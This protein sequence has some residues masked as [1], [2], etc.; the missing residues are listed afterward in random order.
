MYPYEYDGYSDNPP[1]LAATP[2]PS[3]G[4]TWGTEMP[5]EP[6]AYSVENFEPSPPQELVCT[7]CRGVYRDPVEC[8]CRHVF[9]S[10][11]IR[12]WLGRDMSPG[13]RSCPI[14]RR[15]ISMS[16]VVPVVPLVTNMIARLTVRCPNRDTGCTAKVAMESLSCH[17][18]TCEFRR[19]QCPD[20]AAPMLASELST[21]RRESCSR[22]MA[23]CRGDCGLNLGADTQGDRECVR[24]MRCCITR[25]EGTLDTLRQQMAYTLQQLFYVNRQLRQITARMDAL[26]ARMAAQPEAPATPKSSALSPQRWSQKRGKHLPGR[27]L[28]ES[29][30]STGASGSSSIECAD[31]LSMPTSHK[32]RW[33][34]PTGPAFRPVD[35]PQNEHAR[36]CAPAFKSPSDRGPTANLIHDTDGQSGQSHFE[37]YVPPEISRFEGGA[38]LPFTEPPLNPNS[39]V[40]TAGQKLPVFTFGAER[41]SESSLAPNMSSAAF[42]MAPPKSD[43]S[44]RL[45]DFI[46]SET[47]AGARPPTIS[48]SASMNT[49]APGEAQTSTS[50]ME[51]TTEIASELRLDPTTSS[52]GVAGGWQ[53]LP[54]DIVAMQADN[55]PASPHTLPP[56][57]V[58]QRNARDSGMLYGQF[59]GDDCC[60]SRFVQRMRE[61]ALHDDSSD[62]PDDG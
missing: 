60:F 46:L 51:L 33:E 38:F 45:R 32:H 42:H 25:M 29:K 13:S 19:A 8:P 31:R 57:Q 41:A 59:S 14:C 30:T 26:S 5:S 62:S 61:N 11:C 3:R 4:A 15:E 40:R 24:E 2:S 10:T 36:Q 21:H 52:S 17:L 58:T 1:E 49:T 53:T 12:D 39:T 37:I 56:A 47:Q 54:P 44:A 9:C 20:C 27:S 28:F 7:V 23:R 35:P 55:L 6:A 48:H 50:I 34:L 18:E 43:T 16:Q 22:R